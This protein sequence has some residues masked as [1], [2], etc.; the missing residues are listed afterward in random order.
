MATY[1]KGDAVENAVSYELLEKKSGS[2]NLIDIANPTS[3]N[4]AWS[5]DATTQ[6]W[7]AT[8]SNSANLRWDAEL[9]AGDTVVFSADYVVNSGTFIMTIRSAANDILVST[10]VN[11]TGTFT[12]E[13]TATEAGTYRF[14]TAGNQEENSAICSNVSVK[15]KEDEGDAEDTYVSLATASE[16]NFDLSTLGLA[17]GNHTLVVKAKADGYEDSDYSNE[18]VYTAGA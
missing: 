15:V 8:N 17:A 14:Q 6:Q 4:A 18:V 12:A 9:A 1:V 13:Y 5:Y 10:A 3:A 16:I 2:E 7:T 11:K